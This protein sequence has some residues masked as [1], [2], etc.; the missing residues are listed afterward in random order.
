M[1][2]PQD[3]DR[4]TDVMQECMLK[5]HEQRCKIMDAKN[6]QERERLMQMHQEILHQYMQATKEGGMMGQ[7]TTGDDTKSGAGACQ[8]QKDG[9]KH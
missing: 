5:M 1:T 2:N 8:K 9:E 6:P 4:Q 3:M 7:G